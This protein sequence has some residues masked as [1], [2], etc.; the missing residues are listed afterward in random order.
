MNGRVE[1][2]EEGKEGR[3]GKL[4]GLGMERRGYM[5]KTGRIKENREKE[6]EGREGE[7]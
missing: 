3:G 7:E 1:E 6:G 2:W 4:K 5:R